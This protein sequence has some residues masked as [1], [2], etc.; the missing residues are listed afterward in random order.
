MNDV[1]AAVCIFASIG[2]AQQPSRVDFSPPDIL[3]G[4]VPTIDARTTR[5]ITGGDISALNHKLIDDPMEARA[6]I[7]QGSGGRWGSE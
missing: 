2:H 1:L 6:L 5:A 3:I 4:K 7:G